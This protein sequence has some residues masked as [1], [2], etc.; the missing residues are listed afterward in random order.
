MNPTTRSP[1][2]VPV[3]STGNPLTYAQVAAVDHGQNTPPLAAVRDLP[4][5]GQA[6][7]FS[8]SRRDHQR[9]PVQITA[10]ENISNPS[11]AMH[12]EAQ[13]PSSRD[14]AQAARRNALQRPKPIYLPPHVRTQNP[15]EAPITSDDTIS[16]DR[17]R[18]G[19]AQRRVRPAIPNLPSLPKM[20]HL[21]NN[22]RS[23]S[24]ILEKVKTIHAEPEERGNYRSSSPTLSSVHKL[25]ADEMQQVQK[26]HPRRMDLLSRRH[27][28]IE[29]EL[30][31]EMEDELDIGHYNRKRQRVDEAIYEGRSETKVQKDAKKLDSALRGIFVFKG[32]S[33]STSVDASD[34]ANKLPSDEEREEWQHVDGG[35]VGADVASSDGLVTLLAKPGSDMDDGDDF[36]FVAMPGGE[37]VETVVNTRPTRTWK[38][39]GGTA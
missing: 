36:E 32:L 23:K 29:E 7:A 26:A 17:L 33:P 16:L 27:T 5:Q 18:Q 31:H 10:P 14:E 11:R 34:Y 3:I 30:M 20:V 8:G 37:V 35:A 2:L 38:L 1:S 4:V 22:E 6:L 24:P 19:D 25:R 13:A 39:F 15:D 12:V 28:A 9:Q 21:K